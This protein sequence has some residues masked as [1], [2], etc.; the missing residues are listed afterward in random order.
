MKPKRTANLGLMGGRRLYMATFA[1]CCI[2]LLGSPLQGQPVPRYNGGGYGY[3]PY[4]GVLPTYAP[5]RLSVGWS[6][7]ERERPVSIGDNPYPVSGV[8]R[9]NRWVTTEA[10]GATYR[11]WYPGYYVPQYP[12]Y[13]TPYGY[14]YV[15]W[16]G[17]SDFRY[18]GQSWSGP[19]SQ[20]LHGPRGYPYRYPGYG[21]PGYVVA[22]PVGVGIVTPG[23]ISTGIQFGVGNG[24][25]YTPYS[26]YGFS[27]YSSYQ[28]S[29]F[30]IPRVSRT[31]VDEFIAAEGNIAPIPMRRGAVRR[32]AAVAAAAALEEESNLAALP[33]DSSAKLGARSLAAIKAE[34]SKQKAAQEEKGRGLIEKSQAARDRGD[35]GV[36]KLYL[37]MASEILGHSDEQVAAGLAEI[38]AME[39]AK[40][41]DAPK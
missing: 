37:R 24:Y 10:G 18:D 11:A 35:L 28:S 14:P 19:V 32:D 8:G 21:Y 23:Y 6:V 31:R 30:G 27:G 17:Y 38:E 4:A 41:G 2:W 9:P 15:G 33:N 25:P 34:K 36:A 3:R 5:G 7:Q 40:R 29:S 39:R 16:G 22:Q 13:P 12:V 26:G 1:L 20:Y